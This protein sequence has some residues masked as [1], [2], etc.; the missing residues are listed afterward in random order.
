[1]SVIN[2][3]TQVIYERLRIDEIGDADCPRIGGILW[4]GL[5]QKNICV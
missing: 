4:I 1:M 2:F 5:V 3:D